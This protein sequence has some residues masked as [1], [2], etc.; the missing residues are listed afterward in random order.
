MAQSSLS[1]DSLSTTDKNVKIPVFG[2][3]KIK[4]DITFTRITHQN[5]TLHTGK[6]EKMVLR[7]Q[8]MDLLLSMLPCEKDECS[9][10]TVCFL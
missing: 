3:W 7:K 5:Y 2:S 4:P 10:Q 1:T 8:L 9:Y 6:M